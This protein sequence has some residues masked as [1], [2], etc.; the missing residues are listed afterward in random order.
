[1]AQEGP[2]ASISGRK[3]ASSAA[4]PRLRFLPCFSRGVDTASGPLQGLWHREAVKVR[5]PPTPVGRLSGSLPHIHVH[6]HGLLLFFSLSCLF[7]SCLP[8]LPPIAPTWKHQAGRMGCGVQEELA[9]LSP[10]SRLRNPWRLFWA[11]SSP[12]Q[13]RGSHCPRSMN[14]VCSTAFLPH[15][16]DDFEGQP[17]APPLA[18]PIV[19]MTASWNMHSSCSLM[20]L[21][22]RVTAPS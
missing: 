2:T 21:V 20:I 15:P 1:M 17:C 9:S 8:T 5:A 11:H 16:D 6:I 22:P 12:A 18:P 10:K 14:N 7:S 13:D 3:P 19:L 4:S